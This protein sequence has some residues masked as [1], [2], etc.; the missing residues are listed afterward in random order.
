MNPCSSICPIFNKGA[1]NTIEKDS[2]VSS[3]DV[4]GKLDICLQKTETRSMLFVTLYKYQFKLDQE[5]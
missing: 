2:L 3:T 5:P 4:V 1:K